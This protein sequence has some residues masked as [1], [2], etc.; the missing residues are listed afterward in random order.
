MNI[1]LT[2]SH[3]QKELCL[4]RKVAY[5]AEIERGEQLTANP[6]KFNESAQTPSVLSQSLRCSGYDVKVARRCSSLL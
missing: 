5:V 6:F 1:F 3:T 2:L 4:K